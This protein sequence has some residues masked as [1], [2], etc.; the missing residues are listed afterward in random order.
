M[1]S[2][3]RIPWIDFVRILASFLVVL[4]HSSASL[5]DKYNEHLWASWWVGNI[6]DSIARICVPLFFMLSGYL[7]L[8]REE[9]IQV[10]F[11]K[12][13]G[14]VFI[15]FIVWSLIFVFWNIYMEKTIP[16]SASAFYSILFRPAYYHLWFFYAIIGLYL[17]MPILR[18]FVQKAE[19]SLLYYFVLLWMLAVAILPLFAKFLKLNHGYD[20][21]MISGFVGYLVLG[22][23]VGRAPRSAKL[24]VAS[25]FLAISSATVTALGTYYVTRHNENVLDQFFYGYLSLNV[26]VN[27]ASIFYIL[28]FFFEKV[29]GANTSSYLAAVRIV[30]AASLG[31]YLV[32]TMFLYLL[33]TGGLGF[34]LSSQQGNPLYI[35]PLVAFTAYTLS[36]LVIFL[37]QKIPLIKKVVP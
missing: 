35:V 23:L 6:Y 22:H 21:N 3:K 36:F 11:R 27:S 25:I 15:P 5:L 13:L 7:L 37:L 33:R 20:L 28:K 34:V 17:F 18:V 32:H 30:S 9:P 1:E 19:P 2:P 31:I 12:R 14:K 8:G 10:F 16:A 24:L 26:I 4:L 29:D